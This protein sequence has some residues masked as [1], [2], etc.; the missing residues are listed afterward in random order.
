MKKTFSMA[1][2]MV[3]S[4]AVLLALPGASLGAESSEGSEES[5]NRKLE[6]LQIE[7]EVLSANVENLE[8]TM[9]KSVNV[10]GYMDAEYII[11]DQKGQADG[12]RTHHFSFFLEKK[13]Y[14]KWSVFSELE[15]EDAPYFEAGSSESG[16][17]FAE[18]KILLEQAYMDYT[19]SPNLAFRVGRF[20][21]PAGIWNINHYPPFVTTQSRPQHIRHIFPQYLDGFEIHGSVNIQDFMVNYMGYAANGQ[22]NPGGG[23]GN[24][25]K[26]FGGR[27]EF[28]VPFMVEIKA[29]VS[30]LSDELNDGTAKS[31]TGVDMQF[32]VRW[33]KIQAEYAQATMDPAEGE[34]YGSNG[35]YVQAQTNIGKLTLFARYDVFNPNDS[36]PDSEVVVNT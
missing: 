9:A 32:R 20:L 28:M 2:V 24:E 5:L 23:D 8:E 16:F 27:L 22:G 34:A 3:I 18:G 36:V 4:I 30:A 13:L 26:A 33:L 15:F 25:E 1:V 31:A 14:K 17:E 10:S 7:I 21:T 29:G 35:Y 19:S 12:F 6:E 11:N